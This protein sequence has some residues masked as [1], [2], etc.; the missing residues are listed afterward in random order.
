MKRMSVH[1][2]K[3]HFSAVLK[4]VSEG[5]T[6]IVTKHGKPFAEIK[7]VSEAPRGVPVIGAFADTLGHIPE[8]AM[9][10]SDTEL[11]EMFGE[12]YGFEKPIE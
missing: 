6:V 5:E 4:E 12:E 1:E 9:D 7:P 10:W 11:Y 3:A 8:D 2:T